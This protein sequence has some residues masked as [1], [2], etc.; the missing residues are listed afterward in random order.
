MSYSKSKAKT[1]LVDDVASVPSK[2]A[3]L[4][5]NYIDHPMLACKG[6]GFSG[7]D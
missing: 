2:L 4:T 6:G 1:A 7:V 3:L 5:S